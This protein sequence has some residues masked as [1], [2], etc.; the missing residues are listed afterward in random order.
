MF[1]F[2]DI[3]CNFCKVDLFMTVNLPSR[4]KAGTSLRLAKMRK[5]IERKKGKEK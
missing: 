5:K 3:A 1:V 4:R 2:W